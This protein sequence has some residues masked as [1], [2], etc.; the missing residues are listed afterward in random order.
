MLCWGRCEFCCCQRGPSAAAGAGA[1]FITGIPAT[2]PTHNLLSVT[3]ATRLPAPSV[4]VAECFPGGAPE[5]VALHTHPVSSFV[6]FLKIPLSSK[7]QPVSSQA[8]P[9][10]SALCHGRECYILCRGSLLFSTEGMDRCSV[11]APLDGGLCCLRE[12][13]VRLLPFPVFTR[14]Q[15]HPFINLPG[16]LLL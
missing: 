3:P 14:Y 1:A 13:T 16:S 5:G 15:A 8:L 7:L 9:S 6:S 11:Q 12:A 10:W 4:G 2:E